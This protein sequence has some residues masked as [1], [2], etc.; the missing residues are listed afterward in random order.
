MLHAAPVRRAPAVLDEQLL[1]HMQ[2]SVVGQEPLQARANVLHID[3][4]P[5]AL[6]D[7]L[8]RRRKDNKFVRGL[9]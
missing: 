8:G 1:R 4:P 7:G 3:A 9:C 2:D 6:A 5:P